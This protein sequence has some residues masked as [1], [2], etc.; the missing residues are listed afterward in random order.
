MSRDDFWSRRRAAV[1]AEN[2]AQ[3]DASER[4]EVLEAEREAEARFDGQPD[5]EVLE[6]LGLPDPET[7]EEG[8]DFK[9]FLTSA[10]PERL[11]RV[12]L[13]RLWAS[14]PVLANV[15]GLVEYGEDYTDA[16]TVIENLTTAYQVGKGMTAHVEEM[17]R[18]AEEAAAE[19]EGEVASEDIDAAPETDSEEEGVAV[20]EDDDERTETTPV[21]SVAD[22]TPETPAQALVEGTDTKYNLA[23]PRRMRYAFDSQQ[24]GTA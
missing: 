24:G 23:R 7:L 10:V 17:A 12:A 5:A 9:A 14:N 6:A 1:A 3:E 22:L 15:D 4:A 21:E 18:Q 11:K 20:A 13:R 2:A 19:A 16:A 8:D